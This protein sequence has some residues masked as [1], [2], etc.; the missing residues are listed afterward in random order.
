MKTPKF[1]YAIFLFTFFFSACVEDRFF[2]KNVAIP[3]GSW[4]IDYRPE[5]VVAVDDTLTK[6]NFYV[7]IRNSGTYPYSNLYFFIKT[8][9]PDGRFA[10]DT[11]E[12]TLADEQGKWLGKGSGDIIDHQIMFKMKTA[13]PQ[14]GNYT[15]LFEQGMREKELKHILDVGLRIEKFEQK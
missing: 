8:M 2:E 5:F 15:F 12:C 1:F 14:K 10:I 3:D 4:A 9:F 6:Y 7:N 13:F 11:V